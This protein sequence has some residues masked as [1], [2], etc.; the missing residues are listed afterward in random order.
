MEAKQ[1]SKHHG[2]KEL[3]TVNHLLSTVDLGNEP[4]RVDDVDLLGR[5]EHGENWQLGFLPVIAMVSLAL[6]IRCYQSLST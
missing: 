6:P 3:V 5:Q 2:Q 4:G 1:L